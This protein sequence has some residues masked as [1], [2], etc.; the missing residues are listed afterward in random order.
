MMIASL[1]GE[2]VV[3]IG[4]S[5]IWFSVYSTAK[6]AFRSRKNLIDKAMVFME[7]GECDWRDGFEIARQFNLIRDEFAKIP[8]EKAIYDVNNRK[9]EAPWANNISPV[10]TSCANLFTTADGQDLLFEVV[11]ILVYAQVKKVGI[12][13][14]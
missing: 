12:E 1:D 9:K 3:N 13:V 6:V 4:G 7:R 8:P 10:I 14:E 2:R 11:S 5:D